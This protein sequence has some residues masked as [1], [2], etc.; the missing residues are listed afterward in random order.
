MY[1]DSHE[2][3]KQ[4]RIVTVIEIKDDAYLRWISNEHQHCKQKPGEDAT[5]EMNSMPEI[6]HQTAAFYATDML[7][8]E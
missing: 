3:S 7:Q 6:Y 8:Y 1:E 2:S 4:T 5:T